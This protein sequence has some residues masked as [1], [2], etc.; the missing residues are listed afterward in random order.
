MSRAWSKSR[1]LINE[2]DLQQRDTQVRLL[3]RVL[4]PHRVSPRVAVRR[5]PVVLTVTARLDRRTLGIRAPR[6]MI[7][8][9]V[10]ITVTAVVRRA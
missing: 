6:I 4:A 7:G 3:G 9:Y 10:D 8:R 2:C 1:L 5:R